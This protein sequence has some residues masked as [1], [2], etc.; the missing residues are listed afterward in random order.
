MRNLE[1]SCATTVEPPARSG[2]LL[3]VSSKCQCVLIT[4]FT[5]APPSPLSD[6]WSLG[7][8]GATNVSTTTMPS[9]PWSTTTLPPGPASRVRFSPSGC[10]CIGMAPIRARNAATGSCGRAVGCGV[11]RPVAAR[12][13]SRGKSPSTSAPAPIAAI[14]R[15]HSRRVLLVTVGLTVH[16]PSRVSVQYDPG[17][18]EGKAR[19][20]DS[21]GFLSHPGATLRAMTTKAARLSKSR[22]TSGLQCHK[23]LWWEVHEPDALELQPD[24]VL[25]DLFDQGRQVG[26][27]ARARYPGGVLIDLPH[28]AGAARVAATGGAFLPQVPDEIARQRDMLAG[29]LP[30]VPVGLHC[31]EPWECPFMGRCWP[32]TPDHIRHLAGV[33]PKKTAA[34]LT[35]GITSI[36]DLPAREKLN[37]TQR[38]QLKA[39]AEKRIIVEPTL[40]AELAPFGG[41]V[42]GFLDFET[43]AR[44]IPVWPGMAPW[45]QAAAQFS[46]HERQ[47]D[48]TYTHAAFLAEGPDDARPKLA[49][50]TVRATANAER[51]VMYTPFEKTRIR[52]LQ[53]AVP[54]LS[55]ELAALEAKLIDLHP[56]V[57]N[58][59]YHPDFR[60]SFSLKYIL[61]PLVP[62][63]TYS[64]LVIVDGRVASVEIARLLF[65]ADKIPRQERDRVRQDLLD[66]C[67]RDTWAMVRLVERLRELSERH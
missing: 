19:S 17:G 30:D 27:A 40:A 52:E 65:V 56:V 48:G 13:S 28:H 12:A 4:N 43:I 10:A 62:E 1:F 55:A 64:D 63:L 5:G 21:P 57:K 23:K 50:A 25:Q 15:N 67:E 11:A 58:C 49:A 9:G 36:G 26:E 41:A 46:Y 32:E 54:E 66:Y 2:A 51:V 14:I 44:A 47:L 16:L 6:S 29:P 42:L 35:R 38:R 18:V 20:E 53:R 39:M 45:Q 61:T 8:A 3:S 60:G 22:F 37:F 34:Y 31:F 7:H 24:K 59:V 33:G